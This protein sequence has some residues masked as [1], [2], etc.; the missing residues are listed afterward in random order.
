MYWKNRKTSVPWSLIN[1]ID[2]RNLS[3]I[4]GH[5][6]THL[7][8]LSNSKNTIYP[9][10]SFLFLFSIFTKF[11]NSLCA[12]YSENRNF[13]LIDAMLQLWIN[14]ILE[15]ATELSL[16]KL[17]TIFRADWLTGWSVIHVHLAHSITAWTQT[18][19]KLSSFFL[20]ISR[21]QK[22][23]FQK[24]IFFSCDA[25]HRPFFF[26][27]FIA[28][29]ERTVNDMNS[30]WKIRQIKSFFSI[31][32][33][34]IFC[35]ANQKILA[36]CLITHGPIVVFCLH[37]CRKTTRVYQRRNGRRKIEYFSKNRRKK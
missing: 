26:G 27:E 32:S 29:T 10:K 28:A 31:P 34:H 1:K 13:E 30:F 4:R 15:F 3:N 19:S 37:F 36:K 20:K 23:V 12:N 5:Y 9:R 14:E 7:W 11:A 8:T 33:A 24:S 35:L 17:S 22:T 25:R 6:E 2:C 16:T 21:K 18:L